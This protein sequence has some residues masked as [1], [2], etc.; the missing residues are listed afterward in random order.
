MEK[1]KPEE[2][3]GDFKKKCRIYCPLLRFF[4]ALARTPPRTCIRI[5]LERNSGRSD[6]M[7]S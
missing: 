3:K 1:K 4:K 2:K 6:S 5:L 7:R